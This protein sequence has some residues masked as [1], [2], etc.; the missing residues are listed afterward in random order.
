MD[1]EFNYWGIRSDKIDNLTP[2]D[3][4]MEDIAKR[5]AGYIKTVQ[6]PGNGPYY[7]AGWS[8]GGAIAFETARQLEMENEKTAFLGMIDSMPPVKRKWF[9][10]RKINLKS[11]MKFARQIFHHDK[12]IKR[13]KKVKTLEEFWP[14]IVRYLE[15]GHFDLRIFKKRI[16][17]IGMDALTD[18][19][20]MNLREHVF[21]LNTI[22]SLT[23][24]V[25]NYTPSAKLQIP[26]IYFQAEKSGDVKAHQWDKYTAPS[27]QYFKVPGDHFSVLMP[28]N[29]S[30]FAETFEE[31]LKNAN[32]K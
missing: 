6:P 26:M 12:I 14:E 13:L 25:N 32:N 28:P 19:H 15:A 7:I 4:S 18:F 30:S 23:N 22:R 2:C 27:I 5:Y 17:N 3:W 11:E 20:L 8:I 10:R 31:A 9:G 21:Y 1:V 24:M 16:K 29:V